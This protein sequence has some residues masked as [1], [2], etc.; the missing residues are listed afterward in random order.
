MDRLTAMEVFTRVSQLGSFT[1]TSLELG[2]SKSA[3]S[4]HVKDL[5]DQVG[6]R[7][8]NRTTRRVSLTEVGVSYF[9]RCR[10]ILSDVQHLELAA[11]DLHSRPRGTLR[12]SA[13]VSFGRLHL[14]SAIPEF[15]EHYPDVTI[16][17]T[18]NDRFVDLVDEGYDVAL[19]ISE[20]LPDSSFMLRR[21]APCD[22]FLIAAPA[23]LRRTGRPLSPGDLRHHNCILDRNMKS[24]NQWQIK[25]PNGKRSVN[26]RGNLIVN[27]ADASR[28]AA[29][30]GLGVAMLP[31][32]VVEDDVRSGAL[33][34]VLEDWHLI[35][36]SVCAVYP[37]NRHLSTKVRVF[38]DFLAQRFGDVSAEMPVVP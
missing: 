19:R 25:G 28:T 34:R 4:R 11:N 33:V 22:A 2:M 38:V 14:A 6:V 29:V 18:L 36:A 30:A 23:Y 16:D 15:L 9:E 17:L 24:L 10:Q 37:H 1:A 27:S 31:S 12:V 20:Q 5:E 21:I 7:L 35:H 8:F 32:F 3:I 26:V 13:P